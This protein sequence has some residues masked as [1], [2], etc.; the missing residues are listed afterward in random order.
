MFQPGGPA[1]RLRA[2]W[3][4]GQKARCQEG[5]TQRQKVGEFDLESK[6]QNGGQNS[7][8]RDAILKLQ[9]HL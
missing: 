1:A 9:T 2:N 7:S 3:L 8:E 5:C 6:D 4:H